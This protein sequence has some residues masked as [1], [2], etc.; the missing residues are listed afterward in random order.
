MHWVGPEKSLGHFQLAV[1][2]PTSFQPQVKPPTIQLCE[3]VLLWSWL[4]LLVTSKEFEF[5]ATLLTCDD[6][7]IKQKFYTYVLVISLSWKVPKQAEWSFEFHI[8]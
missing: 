4:N 2:Y 8:G 6:V 1:I 7:V 3:V 5:I